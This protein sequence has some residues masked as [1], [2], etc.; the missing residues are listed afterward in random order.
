LYAA[1]F[2][3]LVGRHWS[4]KAP[5]EMTDRNWRI[6]FEDFS[7]SC[8][9][10]SVPRPMRSW[11]ESGLG[12]ELLRAV[13]DAGYRK[14]SPIQMAAI[15]LGLQQRDAIGVAGT[16]SGK[17]AAFVLPMLAYTGRLPPMT[18]ANKDEGPYAVVLVPTHELAKQIEGET[19][20]CSLS[21]H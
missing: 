6:F 15:P 7:I 10:S 21:M 19:E 13:K 4:E 18:T 9:G 17:T 12:A 16:G 3:M 14:P 2:D 20:N 5:E 11:S 1:A 8:K